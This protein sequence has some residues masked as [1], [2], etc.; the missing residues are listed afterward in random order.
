MDSVIETKKADIPNSELELLV[1]MEHAN[2]E[3]EINL[4]SAQ[5]I[6]C[7]NGTDSVTTTSSSR[8][9]SLNS[10]DVNSTNDD[11][12]MKNDEQQWELWNQIISD[13]MTWS[14]KKTAVLKENVRRGIPTHFRPIAWQHLAGCDDTGLKDEYKIYL[15]KQSAY[16]KIIRRDIDRTY[17]EHNFFKTGVGQESLFNIMK[18]YSI[19]DPEVGYCQGSA[20]I[21]GLLLLQNLP[22]EEAFAIFTQVMQQ[23]NLREIFKPNMYHLGLCMYQLECCVQ[24]MLP[25]LHLHFIAHGF[26]TSM[27]SSSWFLTLFTTSL[28]L[29]L[30]CR[31]VDVF[32]SEGIEILFRVALA[33]LDF[34]REFLIPLDMEGMLK[35]FQKELPVK[36]ENDHETILNRAFNVKYNSK[37][38]K[39]YEKD[40][41]IH[42]NNEQEEQAEIRRYRNENKLLKQRIDNLEK[43]SASLAERLIKGQ[44]VNAQSNEALDILKNENL[45]LKDRMNELLSEKN[46][47]E[48]QAAESAALQKSD[49]EN[50]K[51]NTLNHLSEIRELQDKIQSLIDDN[52]SL[53]DTPEVQRLE[54]ELVQIK[55]RDA[56]ANLAVKELQKTIHVLNLEYQ[57]FLNKNF[58]SSVKQGSKTDM[59]VIE[60]ELIKVKLREAEAQSELKA[61]TLKLMQMETEKQVAYN[62]IKRQD[63]EI[64]KLEAITVKYQNKELDFKN[65]LNELKRHLDDKEA[66]VKELNMTHKLKELED[67]HVIAELRQRVAALEVQIQ[68]LVTTGQLYTDKNFLGDRLVDLPDEMKSLLLGSSNALHLNFKEN[69]DYFHKS[70]TMHQINRSLSEPPKYLSAEFLDTD[71]EL[72]EDEDEYKFNKTRSHSSSNLTSS[73]SFKASNSKNSMKAKSDDERTNEADLSLQEN[74]TKIAEAALNGEMES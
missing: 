34:H 54:E 36:H 16:E 4:K 48:E 7:K 18:A 11:Q 24:E 38:M 52:N 55:L 49:S 14:K 74:T 71:D 40:Y 33:L 41:S 1:I 28:T 70:R 5:A 31:I 19:H 66:K 25:D 17:P 23:Y 35:Y 60:E 61:L 58:G 6:L 50:K 63:D 10:F 15:K 67:S 73:E 57:E 20:F 51:I 37:K 46:R 12:S 9:G 43:E 47:N 13:W 69:R 68:E 26:Q 56:E 53:R 39:K 30:V 44:V 8:R 72:D 64:K 22:E 42:K 32:L 21:C 65:N 59:Q 62:Q 29:P 45:K 2:R 3:M 27:Y